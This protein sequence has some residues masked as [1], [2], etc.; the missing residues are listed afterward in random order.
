MHTTEPRHIS[1]ALQLLILSALTC[2]LLVH[3]TALSSWARI[4]FVDGTVQGSG[5]GGSWSQPFKTIQESL[6]AAQ[7]WDQVWIKTGTYLLDATLAPDVPIALV[8]GFAG[9]ES[10]PAQRDIAANPTVID[11]NDAT[12]CLYITQTTVMNGLT[13]QRGNDSN[14]TYGFV[15]GGGIHVLGA[16]LILRHCTIRENNGS[17]CSGICADQSSLLLVGCT[18]RDNRVLSDPSGGGALDLEQSSATILRSSFV[19]NS[20]TEGGAIFIHP[21]SSALIG[22][23]IF[24]GNAA[25]FGGGAIHAG[26]GSLTLVGCKFNDNSV[27]NAGGAISAGN[28]RAVNCQFVRNAADIAGA[29]IASGSVF[30]NC[31][32]VGNTAGAAGACQLESSILVHCTLYGNTGY[33]EIVQGYGTAAVHNSI[34]WGNEL[35]GGSDSV[36]VRGATVSYSDIEGGHVGTGNID[37]FPAFVNPEALDFHLRP[38]SPC[39]DR[40]QFRCPFFPYR[41]FE[42]DRRIIGPRPDMGM[43]ERGLSS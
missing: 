11:G 4:W 23:S 17:T 2:A 21:G 12:L 36:P 28:M 16:R 25:R 5:H 9:G 37:A 20:R 22:H 1:R 40:A 32:F 30:T 29:A 41:D 19:G 31:L 34:I 27:S 13:I 8:G 42:G 6:D 33:S 26:E 14:G 24:E 7:A 38:D 39:I 35:L 10:S 18:L 3:G 43:D 15:G